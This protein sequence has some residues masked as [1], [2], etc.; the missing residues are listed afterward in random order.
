MIFERFCYFLRPAF[1]HG[2]LGHPQSLEYSVK[3]V[4]PAKKDVIVEHKKTSI[5]Q[6]E[7]RSS[8]A[9]ECSEKRNFGSSLSYG[10]YN[11]ISH[12]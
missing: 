5:P 6:I 4:I 12:L 3:G 9:P 11:D 2:R 8:D 10:C 7:L 1:G